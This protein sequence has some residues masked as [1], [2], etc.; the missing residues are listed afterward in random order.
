MNNKIV[1]FLFLIILFQD[2]KDTGKQ[3]EEW[4]DL[5]NGK[6]I[7]DWIVKIHHYEAGDNFDNTFRV[8]SPGGNSR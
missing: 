2:C 8:S 5:F 3:E 4:I 1:T 6:D 7:N